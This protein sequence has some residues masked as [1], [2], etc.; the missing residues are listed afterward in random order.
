[1]LC[2]KILIVVII[3]YIAAEVPIFYTDSDHIETVDTA[4]F[5]ANIMNSDRVSVVECTYFE[6]LKAN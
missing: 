1:M 6:T 2:I 3:Q 5:Y 4:S